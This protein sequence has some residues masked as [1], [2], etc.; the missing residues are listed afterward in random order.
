M[1]YCYA[2]GSQSERELGKIMWKWGFA[3][4]RS[5]GSGKYRY[6]APDLVA[7]KNK[8]V[9]A[10]ECKARKNYV[11]LEAQELFELR[12]WC[13]RSGALGFL[14]WKISRRGWFFLSTDKLDTGINEKNMQAQALRI[15]DLVSI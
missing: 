10:F 11:K 15:E 8:T 6:T 14:A 7:I 13:E 2:K 12:E 1:K 5:A 9:F 3:V 4:I